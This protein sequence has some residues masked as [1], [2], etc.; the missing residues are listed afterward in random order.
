MGTFTAFFDLGIGI[1]SPLAGLA[2]AIGG[3]PAAFALAAACALGTIL[4]AISLRGVSR[5][6]LTGAAAKLPPSARA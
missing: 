4:V 3:Y 2:A 6:T 1:G 5:E